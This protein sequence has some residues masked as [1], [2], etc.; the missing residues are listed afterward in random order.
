MSETAVI[1]LQNLRDGRAALER[2]RE[3]GEVRE[4]KKIGD[5]AAAAKR[6]AE[7]QGL[8]EDAKRFAAEMELDAK[9]YLGEV[10]AKQAKNRGGGE[11]D[12]SKPHSH[13]AEAVP[14]GNQSSE[15]VPPPTL[16]D[17]GISK[18]QSSEAQ[19]I[20]QIPQETFDH[21]KASSPV[22]MLNTRQAVDLAKR[23]NPQ[24]QKQQ[25]VVDMV[26]QVEVEVENDLAVSTLM[27]GAG[28]LETME[29]KREHVAGQIRR[30]PL[31]KRN[32]YAAQ[33]ERARDYLDDILRL[34]TEKPELGAV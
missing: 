13:F 8:S 6:F 28:Y 26:S 7:A 21:F 4:I 31:D 9:R 33:V 30:L 34:L 2:A 20:A 5:L 11:P 32:E 25:R 1:P 29:T 24:A 23:T 19:Q 17:L 18:K 27:L 10:L 15:V 3:L 12:P 14:A 16:S 22:E